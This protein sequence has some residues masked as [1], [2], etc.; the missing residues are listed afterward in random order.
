MTI[1]R[2]FDDLTKIVDDARKVLAE[3]VGQETEKAAQ[4]DLAAPTPGYAPQLGD[5]VRVKNNEGK[6]EQARV[7]KLYEGPGNLLARLDSGRFAISPWEK[8][9][10]IQAIGFK[11]TPDY[12]PSLGDFVR[13]LDNQALVQTGYVT[14]IH[15]NYRSAKVAIGTLSRVTN[16][17]NAPWH[18]IELIQQSEKSEEAKEV[19]LVPRADAHVES[20]LD[21][22]LDSRIPQ[23]KGGEKPVVAAYGTNQAFED[24]K[25]YYENRLEQVQSDAQRV[26]L[27]FNDFVANVAEQLGFSNPR[28]ATTRDI[29]DMLRHTSRHFAVIREARNRLN[30]VLQDREDLLEP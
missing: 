21:D 6:L 13:V 27:Q 28:S 25:V 9:E 7:T 10:L 11:P 5:L 8:T 16:Q 29:M 4:P 30:G 23:P 1:S 22:S 2:F 19:P 14:Q 15:Q 26:S 18:A 3:V 17:V 20:E 24:L 12:T